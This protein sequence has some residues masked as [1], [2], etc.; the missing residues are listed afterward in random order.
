MSASPNMSDTLFEVYGTAKVAHTDEDQ[1][2][3]AA[4]EVFVGLLKESGINPEHLTDDQ[5]KALWGE[6]QKTA[7]EVPPQFMKGK[8]KKE[9]SEEKEKKDEKKEAAAREWQ[10]K[11]AA[12]EKVAEAD[13]LGRIMAHAFVDETK[14]IASSQKAAEF[15]PFM[16]KDKG[17]EKP[18]HEKGEGESKAEEKKEEEK[19][20]SQDRAA[21]LLAK[22]A[23]QAGG[24]TTP[25]L[26]EQAAQHA[27]EMLKSA[28]VDEKLA[29]A[30]INAV[31]TLGLQ[32]STK[33][34]SA[35]STEQALTLRALEYCES[36]GFPVDWS[37][38]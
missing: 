26:D 11:R 32:E 23:G 29:S 14:K 27:I 17:E 36:A 4:S 38:V 10:E 6:Y 8:G 21:A 28:G 30:R 18:E 33:V 9:E 1:E 3:L 20:E 12:A 5:I 13:A 15:P 25:N 34:A 2:K 31:H 19:K 16:K 37:K 22:L 7:G 24:S 35:Q